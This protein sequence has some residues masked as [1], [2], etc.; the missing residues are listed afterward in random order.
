MKKLFVL[1]LGFALMACTS[2]VDMDDDTVVDGVPAVE[3]EAA[4]A[5]AG[6]VAEEGM[7]IEKAADPVIV[8]EAATE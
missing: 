7:I 6:E 2:P 4:E 8:D 1:A 5:A 3:V